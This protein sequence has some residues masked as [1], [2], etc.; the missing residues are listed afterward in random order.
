MSRLTPAACPR[1]QHAAD[2]Y[3]G[4]CHPSSRMI[5]DAF[6]SPLEL[7]STLGILMIGIVGAG[8]LLLVG[9]AALAARLFLP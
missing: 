4:A 6:P 5:E 9:T 1:C 7:L 3:C 8:S 2:G